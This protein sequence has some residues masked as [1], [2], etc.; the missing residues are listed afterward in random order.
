MALGTT[1]SGLA[2][3]HCDP[4]P[5]CDTYRLLTT[6]FDWSSNPRQAVYSLD[7]RALADLWDRSP[8]SAHASL[9]ALAAVL[10]STRDAAMYAR[11]RA[12]YAVAVPALAH[13]RTATEV[14]RRIRGQLLLQ[15]T[16][17]AEVSKK[18]AK[19]PKPQSPAD[20]GPLPGGLQKHPAGDGADRPCPPRSTNL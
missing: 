13:G 5:P 14:L 17:A 12:E 6:A 16:G 19:M 8:A 9:L 20:G 18:E 1:R 2:D 11:P 3:P 10:G 4:T 15:G 7:R